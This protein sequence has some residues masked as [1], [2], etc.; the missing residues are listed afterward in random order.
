MPLYSIKPIKVSNPLKLQ[1]ITN[2][3]NILAD[4][5]MLSLDL[6]LHKSKYSYITKRTSDKITEIL[7][8]LSKDEAKVFYGLYYN[9]KLIKDE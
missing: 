7:V 8:T 5:S 3:S 1:M 6:T 4:S 2:F 9:I